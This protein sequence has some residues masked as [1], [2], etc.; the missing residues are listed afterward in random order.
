MK[1][2]SVIIVSYN[3][4]LYL[5][6]AIDSVLC[7]SLKPAE[8]IIADDASTDQSIN[9]INHCAELHPTIRTCI[10]KQNIGVSKNRDL[11]AR[12]ASGELITFL[13]GD[14]WYYPDKLKNE[15]Q[16]LAETQCNVVFSD[17]VYVDSN[18]K[19]L[20]TI[21][22]STFPGDDLDERTKWICNRRSPIPRDM[23]ISKSLYIE[24]GGFNE[25]LAI[26]EDWDFKIR[27][28]AISGNW[29]HAKTN[30]TAY[31][32]TGTGLSSVSLRKHLLAQI[33][34]IKINKALLIRHFGQQGYLEILFST[35][36]RGIKRIPSRIVK[37]IAKR[38]GKKD[39]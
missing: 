33:N 19:L 4:G 36:S 34:I 17:I 28:A 39:I 23:L 38:I 37:E 8:I 32:Q 16:T 31:R 26:Y 6:K 15:Y 35:F 20:T 10:R 5:E 1:T 12:Q 2:I 9:I 24:S 13:D 22:T 18:N 29:I 11:A 3:N 25:K 27:L 21:D 7:Q 14:D 30:G